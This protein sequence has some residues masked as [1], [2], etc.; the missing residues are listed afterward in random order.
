MKIKF[1]LKKK[2][3][4]IFSINCFHTNILNAENVVCKIVLINCELICIRSISKLI[5]NSEIN[6]DSHS[7]SKNLMHF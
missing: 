4:Q 6:V 2:N 1:L 7:K 3:K 5:N